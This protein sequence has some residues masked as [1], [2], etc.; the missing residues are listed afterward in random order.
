MHTFYNNENVTVYQINARMPFT[1]LGWNTVYPFGRCI[2]PRQLNSELKVNMHS[3]SRC[4]LGIKAWLA[5]LCTC[6]IIITNS[7]CT[8][9]SGMDVVKLSQSKSS[10]SASTCRS[11]ESKCLTD[12][13]WQTPSIS[14]QQNMSASPSSNSWTPPV[15]LCNRGSNS[16]TAGVFQ[17]SCR[18]RTETGAQ[19]IPWCR[20]V[21]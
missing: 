16:C 11:S 18:D 21:E 9:W 20:G 2:H 12:T 13:T 4:F 10:C 14:E 1:I 6:I 19:M 5:S 7:C 15:F 3:S 17:K 8:W